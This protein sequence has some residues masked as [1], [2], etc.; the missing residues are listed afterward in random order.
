MY[1]AVS[2][3]WKVFFYALCARFGDRSCTEEKA[4]LIY[5]DIFQDGHTL[6]E[7]GSFRVKDS[8]EVEVSAVNLA[9]NAFCF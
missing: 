3:R 5:D 1:A 8:A 4:I 9:A 2:F 6:H 7:A